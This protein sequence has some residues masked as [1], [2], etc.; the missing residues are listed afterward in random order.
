[1]L[2]LSTKALLISMLSLMP[3]GRMAYCKSCRYVLG[4]DDTLKD[5]IDD[6]AGAQAFLQQVP[7]PSGNL[8]TDGLGE[9][10][11]HI[12]LTAFTGD[13]GRRVSNA[14]NV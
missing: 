14:L 12:S 6:F 10:K 4:H 7:N 5:L 1:M 2:L 11:F 8:L 9:P 13:W 3:K